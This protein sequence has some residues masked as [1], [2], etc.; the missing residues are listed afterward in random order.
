M[1]KKKKIEKIDKDDIVGRP[2]FMP[3]SSLTFAVL[4]LACKVNEIIEVLN[5]ERK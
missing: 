1:S 5:E 3:I 2:D 4:A